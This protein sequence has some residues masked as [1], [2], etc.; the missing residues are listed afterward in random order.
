MSNPM[1]SI[2]VQQQTFEARLEC[3]YL[4]HSPEKLD[5]N[6]L[7]ILTLHGYSSNPEAMLR[8]TTGL[9]GEGHVVAALEGPN[10][11]YV[12]AGLPNKE[13]VAGY[14]WGIGAHW[15]SAVLLHHE[16]VLK[17]L[18]EL[19]ERFQLG[20]ERCLLM[21][22][23]QPVGLNY[24][25]AGTHPGEVAGILG[26]CG[27]VPRDWEEDKY[28]PLQAAVLHISRDQDEF[29]PVDV[30]E[31]FPQRLRKHAEDVEFHLLEGPHRFPSKAGPIVQT[32]IQR[33]WPRMNA[34]E[35]K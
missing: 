17:T 20:K 35:R 8:L 27:G 23:S 22:F 9:V 2:T 34:N 15:G 31:K 32:W 10:Q 25:F 4:V 21:G 14:N 7:L 3:R 24:R 13:S 29:Y 12:A 11:Q 28:R 18:A 19:R 6:S 1:P 26:I 5:R 30:V 33:I 16:M